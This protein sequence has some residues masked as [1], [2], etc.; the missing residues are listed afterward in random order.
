MVIAEYTDSNSPEGG[1]SKHKGDKFFHLPERN[2]ETVTGNYRENHADGHQCHCK[3]ANSGIY[4]V[5]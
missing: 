3:N 5:E 4:L 2:I 1:E